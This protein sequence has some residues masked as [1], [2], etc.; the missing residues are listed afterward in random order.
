MKVCGQALCIDPKTK[1]FGD[2]MTYQCDQCGEKI[3]K[4]FEA[5]HLNKAAAQAEKE[6]QDGST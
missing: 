2:V 4:F 6:R 3:N 5:D 1:K